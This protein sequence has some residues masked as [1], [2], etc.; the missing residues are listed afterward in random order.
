MAKD[1]F[2]SRIPVL[3]TTTTIPG[4]S[5]NAT[6]KNKEHGTELHT[7]LASRMVRLGYIVLERSE[8]P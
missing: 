2:T 3:P 4:T 8:N 6:E 5:L 1:Q 7:Y